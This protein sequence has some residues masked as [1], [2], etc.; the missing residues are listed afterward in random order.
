MSVPATAHTARV[1]P[2]NPLG[3]HALVWVDHWDIASAELAIEQTARAGYA[4]IELPMLD[5]GA[6]DAKRLRERITAAGLAARCSLGL[7]FDADISSEDPEI[8]RRGEQR[9]V[10]ALEAASTVGADMLAG[11]LYSALAKY[12]KPASQRGRRNAVDALGRLADRAA[13]LGMTLGLEVVNRYESNVVNTAKDTLRLLDDIGRPNVTVHLDSYHMNI[14]E[15]DLHQ[16]IIAC[17][18]R[19]GYVHVGA[20]H[21]GYLGS[22]HLELAVLFRALVE[23]GYSG[24]ITFEAFSAPAEP[25]GLFD[26]LAIWRRLWDDRGDLA[27]AARLYMESQLVAARQAGLAS[28]LPAAPTAG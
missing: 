11:V 4:L 18:K 20:N 23:V 22:G 5:P 15:V 17:G 8:A 28:G 3:I 24:P 27:R 14:E 10:A 9:L 25:T 7:T 2:A 12:S 1:P 6:V 21:R 19:L 26:T 13:S 16:P